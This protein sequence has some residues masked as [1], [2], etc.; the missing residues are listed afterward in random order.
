MELSELENNPQ[1]EYS[2]RAEK[3]GKKAF[4]GFYRLLTRNQSN[5]IIYV[6]TD[7]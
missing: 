6:I 1:R 4:D 2:I 7:K 3:R 5:G